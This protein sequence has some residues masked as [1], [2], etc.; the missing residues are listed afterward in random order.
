[1]DLHDLVSTLSGLV[2]TTG[3]VGSPLL[4]AD[5]DAIWKDITRTFTPLVAMRAKLVARYREHS[6]T[7]VSRTRLGYIDGL[8]LWLVNGG[9]VKEKFD[10]DFIEGGH[11]LAW[12]FIPNGEVWLDACLASDQLMFVLLHEIVER[13]LMAHG[14]TYE[15][16]HEIAN[17]YESL[18]RKQH[19]WTDF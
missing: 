10:M 1:M 8:E 7:E 2:R 19:G 18:Y 4:P 5:V 9:E 13:K 12:P 3:E 14:L 11:D 15:R 16:A 6:R 17:Y